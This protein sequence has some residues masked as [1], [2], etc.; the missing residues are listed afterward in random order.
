VTPCGF[1]V[2]PFAELLPGIV[3]APGTYI[4]NISAETAER[5]RLPPDCGVCAGTTGVHHAHVLHGPHV[6]YGAMGLA[7]NNAL[8]TVLIMRMQ[9]V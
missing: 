4:S 3:V 2:Q 1:H 9:I 6:L 8:T 7:L 5:T